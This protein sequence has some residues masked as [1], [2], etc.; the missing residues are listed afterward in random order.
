MC[1]LPK[2][3]VKSED[4]ERVGPGGITQAEYQEFKSLTKALPRKKNIL[5][6]ILEEKLGMTNACLS[7][8]IEFKR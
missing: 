2:G 1:V 6:K 8:Y 7:S 5:V 3:T 4:L